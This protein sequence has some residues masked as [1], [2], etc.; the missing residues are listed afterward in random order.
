MSNRC[1][2]R[3][4]RWVRGLIAFFVLLTCIR[5][6]VGPVEL[7]PAAQAQRS[8]PTTQRILLLEEARRTNQLLGEIKQ[9]LESKTLKVRIVGADNKPGAPV[10]PRNVG[11]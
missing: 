2:R 1:D 4:S 9:L 5:V 3:A 11:G 6:W 8:N 10:L 7:L